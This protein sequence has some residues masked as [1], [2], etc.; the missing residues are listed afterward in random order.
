M[1]V[2]LSL[3]F[4]WKSFLARAYLVV[5]AHLHMWLCSPSAA[6]SCCWPGRADHAPPRMAHSLAQQD[7]GAVSQGTE[8][9][10]GWPHSTVGS[11]QV[12]TC[13]RDPQAL[14]CVAVAK[15]YS[16]AHSYGSIKML[17]YMS[18]PQLPVGRAGARCQMNQEQAELSPSVMQPTSHF[19]PVSVSPLGAHSARPQPTELGAPI[20]PKYPVYV[21]ST[22][23]LSQ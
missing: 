4:S 20:P 6:Y 16:S 7:W 2:L 14:F 1:V 17:G 10:P 8:R 18:Q 23:P 21:P 15:S 19:Q 11:W 22:W 12:I 13:H 9:E 3:H 5:T